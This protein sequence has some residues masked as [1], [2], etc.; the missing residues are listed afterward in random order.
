MKVTGAT[1]CKMEPELN[2]GQ[3]DQSM[4]VV[5]KKA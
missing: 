1:I 5:T 2:L 4:K 3:M